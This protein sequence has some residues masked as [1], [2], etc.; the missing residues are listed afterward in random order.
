MPT[1]YPCNQLNRFSSLLSD[2]LDMPQSRFSITWSKLGEE[3]G[4]LTWLSIPGQN[5]L[6]INSFEA[7]KEL[8]DKRALI[9]VERPRFTMIAELLGGCLSPSGAFDSMLTIEPS[10]QE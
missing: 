10:R 9:F 7:A 6:V 1:L 5:I 2:I 4:P 3:Y 8:L